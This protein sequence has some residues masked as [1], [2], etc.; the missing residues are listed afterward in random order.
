[1]N[2]RLK[3]V[4]KGLKLSQEFVAKQLGMTRTTIVAIEAGTRKVTADE[5]TKF[6]EL[7]GVTTDE[8]L[9]GDVSEENEVKAFARTFSELSDID[10]KE[11]MNLINF[12]RRYKEGMRLSNYEIPYWK[13]YTLSI[14]EAAA[15]F[16]IGEGKLRRL[17]QENPRAD[18]LLWNGN[19]VQIKRE[20][21]EKFIDTLS[22]V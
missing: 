5:L 18:Y 4:R 3:Q 6:S 11:I 12:K 13:K 15:Y 16:R 20:K 22:A 7:Y 1:M 10:K 9:Y 17:V 19:R 8:L 21:F 2:E 14:E